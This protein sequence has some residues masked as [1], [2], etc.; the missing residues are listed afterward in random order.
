[1]TC[2]D[3]TGPAWSGLW[4]ENWQTAKSWTIKSKY[5]WVHQ[6]DFSLSFF[7]LLGLQTSF[8]TQPSFRFFCSKCGSDL[9]ETDALV[10]FC[11]TWIYEIRSF[12]NMEILQ[13]KNL[14]SRS[15]THTHTSRSFFHCLWAI[16]HHYHNYSYIL[17]LIYYNIQNRTRVTMV[18]LL[19]WQ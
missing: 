14:S 3:T 17:H 2:A 12:Q 8:E 15:R 9:I 18:P 10:C 19:L 6:K 1:M 16:T 13:M 7:L 4:P 11:L 5:K